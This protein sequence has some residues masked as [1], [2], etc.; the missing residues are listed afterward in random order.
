M[1]RKKYY[2]ITKNG[3]IYITTKALAKLCGV[4]KKLLL[5]LI[6]EITHVHHLDINDYIKYFV[7]RSD[8]TNLVAMK[9]FTYIK[10]Y[11]IF[12]IINEKLNKRK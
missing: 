10:E 1:K 9:N 5:C 7:I 4:R 6:G 8:Y 2:K 3:D 12:N 11:G